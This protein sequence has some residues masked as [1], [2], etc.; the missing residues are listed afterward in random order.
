MQ[1]PEKDTSFRL[2]RREFLKGG[3]AFAAG[4][5]GAAG[6]T[7]VHAEAEGE[8]L[9]N[10]IRLP[11]TWPPQRQSLSDEPAAP[12][13]LTAP[14]A[15]IPI[16]VGRQLFVDDFLIAATT[17]QRTFHAAEYHPASPILKPDR[18]WEMTQGSPT[19]MAFSDGAWYDPRDGLFK[20]WYMGGYTTTT[21]Y[22]TSTDGI[23]WEK[24]ALDVKPGTNIVL[25]AKR[26]SGTVW[27]DLDD[28]DPAR[29]FKLSR[30]HSLGDHWGMSIH[31]SADG[32]HWSAPVVDTGSCGD[33]STFFR[34]PFRK[35]WVYSLRHGWGRPRRRRYFE[36]RD[37]V[38]GPR[39]TRIDEPTLWAGADRLDP[40]REDFRLPAELYNLDCVAY[41]SLL[42][43]LFTIWRGQ[44]DERPKPNQ[45]HL[46]FSRDG[47][48]WHRPERRA[49]LRISEQ[50]GDWNWGNVQ[51]VGG[52]CLVIGDRLFF[53][54]SG[55]TFGSGTPPPAVA[56]TGLA[57]LRRDGFASMD[58]GETEG[59]LTT[60]PVQFRGRH[61]FVNLDAPAGELRV[62]VLDEQDKPLAPFSRAN[63]VPVHAD[64][65]RA[66]V[67]WKGATD[68]ARLAGRPV[69]FRFHLRK[70]KLYAFWVSPE[71]AGASHGYVAAGGPGLPGALDTVGAARAAK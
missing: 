39:W 41:E 38:S 9:Y 17:L 1:A 64:Q 8:L 13:Y 37:M 70:A 2:G 45:V 23:H 27:L 12:P 30:A 18:P 34:N 65:T 40:P 35:V 68:L 43:G 59:T 44:N 28:P 11:A 6:T 54:C 47:F 67:R 52:G 19:A 15:V 31:Y 26:D 56:T 7:L 24:P 58:A 62:E 71:T 29:R 51:S 32:I 14:P 46:G 42:L 60:R 50:R 33:R 49:F 3:V 10:G 25:E 55:R 36:T 21:C 4:L 22:A 16:D 63:C 48:N 69:R 20:L 5:S 61:L 57:T 53:Y 66:P